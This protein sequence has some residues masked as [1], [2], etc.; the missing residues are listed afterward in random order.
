MTY[1]LKA[2]RYFLKQIEKLSSADKSR[3]E[4]KID[5]LLQNPFRYKKLHSKQFSKV[6][7]IRITIQSKEMRLVYVVLEP[8]VIL[9]ALLDRG[10]E[11][12]DLE[13]YLRSLK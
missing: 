10:D 9:V 5:L 12:K 8:N 3:I 7:R 2:T 1:A 11:Y 4:E 13:K 6:F